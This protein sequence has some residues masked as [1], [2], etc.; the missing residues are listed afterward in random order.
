MLS[1]VRVNSECTFRPDISFYNSSLNCSHANMDSFVRSR[2]GL[3]SSR[4]EGSNTRSE[5]LIDKKVNKSINKMFTM[6]DVDK[7]NCI[8]HKTIYINSNVANSN[9]ATKGNW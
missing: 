3:L 7:D 2:S 4:K 8:T 1:L 6:L 5:V 9:S